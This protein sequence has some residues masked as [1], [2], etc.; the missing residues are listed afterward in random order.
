[1]KFYGFLNSPISQRM[2]QM[3]NN[4]VPIEISDLREVLPPNEQIIYSTTCSVTF[5]H[6]FYGTRAKK[7]RIKHETHVLITPRGFAYFSQNYIVKAF[8]KVEF[9]DVKPIYNSLLDVASVQE[10]GF[11]FGQIEF[12][13]IYQPN[14]ESKET[15]KERS[16]KFKMLLFPYLLETTQTFL[17]YVLDNKDK[18]V[19]DDSPLW[20]I[21]SNFFK[22]KFIDFNYD[23]IPDGEILRKNFDILE[24]EL[25]SKKLYQTTVFQILDIL[26]EIYRVSYVTYDY[27]YKNKKF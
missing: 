13:F 24:D 16:K 25:T 14:Y 11:K 26:R 27:V 1:M 9:F 4:Y 3:E 12:A 18:E 19:K 17:T 6:S 5:Y 2:I 8:R 23:Q 7:L 22:N 10:G 15:F 20:K 21:N